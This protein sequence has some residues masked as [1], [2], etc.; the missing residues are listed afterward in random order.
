MKREHTLRK[1][2]TTK[3][4][5]LE[6]ILTNSNSKASLKS[7][8]TA[9]RTFDIFCKVKVGLDDPDI[10]D[11][12]IEKAQKLKQHALTSMERYSIDKEYWSQLKAR[13]D[14]VYRIARE[15]VI[16]QY[17]SWFESGDVQSICTSIQSWIRFCSQDH[18]EVNQHRHMTWK[19][20]KSISI[21]SYWA[22]IKDFLRICHG[23]RI[24]S[25]DVKDYLKFPK[26]T[27]QHPEPL[28]L[29]HIKLILAHAD[30]KRR[31]LYYVLLTSGMRTGEGLSLKRSNFKTDVR[32][33]RIHLHAKDTKTKEARDTFI[34]EEAWERVKP[35][36][37]AT[38]EGK[39]LFHDYEDG[40]DAVQTESRY[41]LR[42]REKIGEKYGHKNPCNEFPDGTGVLKR[43]EDS[44]RNCVHLHAM[45]SYFMTVAEGIH[46]SDY[47]H[48]LAGHHTYLDQYIRKPEKQKAKMYL[49]LEKHLLLESSKVHSEQFHEKEL[50]ELR[51]EMQQQRAQIEKLM[52]DKSATV[53]FDATKHGVTS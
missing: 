19:A 12:N 42:L 11:L 36:Y 10:T 3:E 7:A 37:D 50:S 48:A 27:K 9:L 39:R 52:R 14:D 44:V 28:E 41:F 5:W 25:D 21:K 34:T 31:A 29:E 23:V 43:Y 17:Q 15:Q 33:I 24:T 35:I 6:D 1:E 22:T 18:P 2:Y 32:P 16:Q 47:A 45:R 13:R 20:K 38:E 51:E 46:G 49:E 30:P 53:E 8:E 40:Y 26:D 4:D